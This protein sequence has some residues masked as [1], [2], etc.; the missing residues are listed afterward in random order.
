MA[1]TTT[2]ALIL[3]AGAA[4]GAAG[5]FAEGLSNKKQ[6]NTN[7]EALNE[8]ADF[9]A[10]ERIREAQKLKQQQ[11]VSYLKSGVLLSGT[12]ELV[13]QETSDYA[14]E[15]V[16]QIFKQRDIQAKNLTSAANT[17]MFTS[18]LKGVSS[19][20]LLGFKGAGF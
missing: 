18:L 9:T 11:A 2:T 20:A 16:R 1:V 12:P 4:L 5:G 19:G 15:D 10:S 6:A 8:N 17:R 13:M 14:R 7:I 3:G